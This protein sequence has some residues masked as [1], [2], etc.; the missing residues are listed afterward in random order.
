MECS[1][2]DA[3]LTLAGLFFETH[4][5][6]TA[7]LERR[8]E[9]ECG[10]SVQ[11]F[12]VLLRVARSPEQRLRMQ[13]LV[14]QVTLTSSGLTR[15]VDRLEEAG[16]L[17]RES[18]PSDRRGLYATLAASL[19]RENAESKRRYRS[20]SSI[21]SRRSRVCWINR[22][23]THRFRVGLAQVAIGANYWSCRNWKS[24][25]NDEKQR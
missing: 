24:L 7:T 25:L 11:W 5:G 8:L 21:S 1:L 19:R 6:L 3:R 4:A 15:V 9:A 22:A 17:K 10:L 23:G 16:L 14:A 2:V 18:C 20:I 12:E 13:E